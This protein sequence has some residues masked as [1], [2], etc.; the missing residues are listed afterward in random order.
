MFNFFIKKIKRKIQNFVYGQKTEIEYVE[1]ALSRYQ[2]QIDDIK[3]KFYDNGGGCCPGCY[4]G[5]EFDRLVDKVER[6]EKWLK[7]LKKRKGK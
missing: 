1:A 5:G 2:S 3:K 6:V 4:S 7:I